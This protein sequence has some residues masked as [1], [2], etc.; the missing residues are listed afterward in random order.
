MTTIKVDEAGCLAVALKHCGVPVHSV[1]RNGLVVQQSIYGRD[2]YLG[3]HR[4]LEALPL[5]HRLHIA[6]TG[7]ESP[8]FKERFKN[9]ARR[10]DLDR[11][12]IMEILETFNDGPVDHDLVEEAHLYSR[13]HAQ[14]HRIEGQWIEVVRANPPRESMR[15][16]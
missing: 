7:S 8:L 5:A 9:A 1:M 16:V 4:A 6:L 15:H 12:T 14:R 2:H 11:P 10:C 3:D 13:K